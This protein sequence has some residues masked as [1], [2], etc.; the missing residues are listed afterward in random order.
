[1][2]RE[3][4]ELATFGG[5]VS[6]PDLQDIPINAADWREDVDADS[7]D[8]ILRG[9]KGDT[10]VATTY[11]KTAIAA[12]LI[13]RDI[14]LRD[15]VYLNPVDQRIEA[16]KD[17]YGTPVL[18]G[19][20][21]SDPIV[22]A[23]KAAASVLNNVV[24]Y[25]LGNQAPK[26]AGY[27]NHD[28][29]G[30]NTADKTLFRVLDD[31]VTTG[32]ATPYFH[33]VLADSLYYYGIQLDGIYI[34]KIDKTTG[35]FVSKSIAFVKTRAFCHAE[36]GYAYLFDQ[37]GSDG[38]LYKIQLS[39][40][41][42]TITRTLSAFTGIQS[43][44][45][46]YISDILATT[47]R[48]WFA[49]HGPL[50]KEF[51]D[52][53]NGTNWVYT[54]P[55][56][57]A[58]SSGGSSTNTNRTPLITGGSM[59]VGRFINLRIF[60]D[61][62][63]TLVS[64]VTK[65]LVQ[66][67]PVSLVKLSGTS[68]AWLA[69]YSGG[70]STYGDIGG[71]A[72]TEYHNHIR[73]NDSGGIYQAVRGDVI[74][75]NIGESDASATLQPFHSI[76]DVSGPSSIYGWCG[77]DTSLATSDIDM[78]IVVSKNILQHH[79]AFNNPVPT[80]GV[81]ADQ[82][83]ATKYSGTV[84]GAN[85]AAVTV[86]L[87]PAT[88]A[89]ILSRQAGS[90]PGIEK[91]N[92][93]WTA[94]ITK[95]AAAHEGSNII[96]SSTVVTSTTAFTDNRS[97]FYR[98]SFTFNFTEE[99]P[100]GLLAYR[101]DRAAGVK[102]GA[103]VSVIIRDTA[104]L[105]SRVTAV[106]VYR[107]S[108]TYQGNTPDG[109][110]RRVKTISTT[111]QSFVASGITSMSHSF[112]DLEESIGAAFEA[113]AGYSETLE[114][115]GMQYTLSAALNG[116]LFI[117]KCYHT[118]LPDALRYI[119]K[120]KSFRYST[121][122]RI[123]EYLILPAIPTAMAGWN[124][125]LYVCTKTD[126][127]RINPDGLFIEDVF[128]GVGAIDQGCIVV[129]HAGMFI[130]DQE[131]IYLHD[132]KSLSNIGYPIQ[133]RSNLVSVPGSFALENI[134]HTQYNPIGSYFQDQGSVCYLVSTSSTGN[135]LLVFNIRRGEW[136]VWKLADN[137]GTS[138]VNIFGGINGELYFSDTA[139]LLKIADSGTR[140]IFNWY[141]KVFTGDQT[142]DN[143]KFYIMRPKAKGEDASSVLNKTYSADDAAFVATAAGDLINSADRK[144]NRI[145][146]RLNTSGGTAG[147]VSV[148][149]LSLV[150]RSL[151]GER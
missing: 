132:G 91:I 36:S 58:D 54:I 8:G 59:A 123:N 114:D 111:D 38:I 26:W 118:E 19:N 45:T 115:V 21:G 139:A 92:V 99:S 84:G 67:F 102:D 24:H 141:S 104:L 12:R 125:R 74:A 68:V 35:L 90:A 5:M 50:L 66:T 88:D 31:T 78:F 61:T 89:V 140:K 144:K 64:S 49:F 14:S 65:Q 148:Q 16:V 10:T 37:A 128:H 13:Y 43:T 82:R 6:N 109:F 142:H 131:S 94:N 121:F 133:R 105:S 122:D 87:S 47:N 110:Y 137:P 93:D 136:G 53:S 25:G 75:F 106:N 135:Y 30:I 57:E 71:L 22:V 4:I 124:G 55:R 52:G 95:P 9:R 28:R 18:V 81:S 51:P 34:Y 83:A 79:A 112:D 127:Y 41:T 29:F 7:A 40:L 77:E 147:N 85:F 145:Q 60:S 130:Y 108:G 126:L 113:R 98:F 103:R 97:Y 42:I 27:I 48:V 86:D 117:G 73:E 17:L 101:I 116:S 39:D 100:L 20:G 56:T 134:S 76:Y 146:L 150:F 44:F 138:R 96:I 3:V 143:K 15:L 1:M 129:T 69:R 46:P 149:S 63:R 2:P 119:F 62:T 32:N 70:Y 11:G 80:V 23:E 120:S 72:F 33:K 107:A 151:L